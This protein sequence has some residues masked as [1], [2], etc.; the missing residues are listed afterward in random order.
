M[1]KYFQENETIRVPFE[2]NQWVDLKQELT[3][4]DED[5]ISNKMMRAEGMAASVKETKAEIVM[6]FGKQ[7][8]LERSIVAW[9][10]DVP[11]TPEN[12]SSLRKKYRVKVLQEADRLQNEAQEFS[13]NL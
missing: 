4:A 11:V 2:D 10:F 12:I 13:K 5:Y 7:A 6:D 8:L 9:S 3:Q 1:S